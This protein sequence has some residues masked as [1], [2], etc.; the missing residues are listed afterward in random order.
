MRLTGHS[1]DPVGSG[2]SAR[3]VEPDVQYLWDWMLHCHLPHHMMNHMVS[4]VGPMAHAG[5]G[6]RTGGGMA[7]GMGMIRQGNALS[8]DVGTKFGRGM[9]IAEEERRISNAASMAAQ[10]GRSAT[11]LDTDRARTEPPRAT[12]ARSVF[13]DFPRTCRCPWTRRWPNRRRT[14]WPRTE[15]GHTRDDDAPQRAADR[16][17]RGNHA[18]RGGAKGAPVRFVRADQ[19]QGVLVEP[20]ATL[21][22]LKPGWIVNVT[23]V[24]EGDREVAEI[25]RIVFER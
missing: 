22:D 20:T 23:T 13:R 19:G 9:G 15:G 17:L 3:V 21:A 11:A 5:H 4:M 24:H 16:P 8:E 7:E 6:M 18:A 12:A 2:S 1:V 10:N 14:D 25:V